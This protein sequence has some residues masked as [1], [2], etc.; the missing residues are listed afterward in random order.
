MAVSES[1]RSAN[2][3]ISRVYRDAAREEPA[4]HLGDA[5][6]RAARGTGSP[7]ARAQRWW[8]SWRLPVALATLG[9]V[10]VSLVTLMLE[11]GGERLTHLPPSP[12]TARPEASAPPEA[13]PPGVS[14]NPAQ[15]RAR[16]DS[17]AAAPAADSAL[18]EKAR[19]QQ[20][21]QASEREGA[22]AQRQRGIEQAPA[23]D[24]KSSGAAATA[25]DAGEPRKAVPAVA[26]PSAPAPPA[27]PGA[28]AAA[29]RSSR[30]AATPAPAQQAAAPRRDS[31]DEYRAEIARLEGEPPGVWLERISRLRSE[32]REREADALLIEFR[33]RFPEAAAP[34]PAR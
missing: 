23:H 6:R 12:A 34:L 8:T 13:V 1:E 30:P 19:R 21:T 18:R 7:R 33:A 9:I 11:Q 14:A 5:I 32:G 31:P 28:G 10:S 2:E 29:E 16:G 15:Q 26:E 22:G 17:P 27:I 20:R 24:P 3:R 25:G 4:G